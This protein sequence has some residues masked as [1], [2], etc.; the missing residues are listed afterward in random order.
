MAI[1]SRQIGWSTES[2]L[3]W[4]MNKQLE[5]LNCVMCNIG[6]EDGESGTAGTS[7]LS[8]GS[9]GTSGANGVAGANG[10]S[11]TAGRTGSSGSAGSSGVSGTS[12]TGFTSY[13]GSFY[14]TTTQSV[15]SGTIA[16]MEFNSVDSSCTNGFTIANN[17]SGRPTRITAANTGV[18]NLQFSAQLSRLVGGTSKQIDIWIRKNSTDIAD[19]A[20][21]ITMQANDGK[22]VAAWN[23]F[24]QMNAGQY[25]EIMWTQNDD[26]QIL[27]EGPNLTVPFP[28]I[29][30]VIA[31]INKIG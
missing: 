21:G 31:T 10:S 26:I 16:A 25:V 19:T 27:Y 6:G 30:S 5:T 8:Y 17:G 13:Y 29:P 11:G 2:N 9:S 4:E 15:T 7:G 28:A 24:V 1:P 12:G 3:L 18:Y 20:T 14:D 22:I 23:F